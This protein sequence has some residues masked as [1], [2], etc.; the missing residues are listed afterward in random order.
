VKLFDEKEVKFRLVRGQKCSSFV[1]SRLFLSAPVS[2]SST[3]PAKVTYCGKE[4]MLWNSITIIAI[5]HFFS[6]RPF[7]WRDVF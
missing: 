4:S 1:S 3:R 5:G 7:D 2:L 6:F